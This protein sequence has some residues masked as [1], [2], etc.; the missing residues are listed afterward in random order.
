MCWIGG[1]IET[2]PRIAKN[3]ITV[4]KIGL[5]S[6]SGKTFTSFLREYKYRV[7]TLQK[8]INLTALPS[9]PD[10]GLCVIDDGYHSYSAGNK[11][12]IDDYYISVFMR[13]K[14][15]AVSTG[16]V[17]YFQPVSIGKFI[18]PKGTKYY[19]NRYGEVV[20][21]QI[22]YVGLVDIQ[23]EETVYNNNSFPKRRFSY[24]GN[25]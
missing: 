2:R 1:E 15:N 14:T 6:R 12:Q 23:N 8:K 19:I 11:I 16:R 17:E 18:I 9:Y 5:I 22:M 20:S 13:I 3:D 10:S 21:E 4:Y 25:K 7:G 24:Y